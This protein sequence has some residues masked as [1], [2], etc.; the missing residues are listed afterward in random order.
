M[1]MQFVQCLA[2]APLHLIDSAFY[3]VLFWQVKKVRKS[4]FEVSCM[5]KSG[6]NWKW[7]KPVDQIL[8]KP[9]DIKSVI[10]PPKKISKRDLHSVP[11]LSRWL[12]N[13]YHI[14]EMTAWTVCTSISMVSQTIPVHNVV[15]LP[16]LGTV[17][18]LGT[19]LKTNSVGQSHNRTITSL[20]VSQ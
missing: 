8:Y 19:F 3:F 7:P 11:E 15:K 1:F 17:V 10:R 5:K 4:G 2:P 12:T 6:N 20:T 16:V 18:V 9:S 14:A 13:C